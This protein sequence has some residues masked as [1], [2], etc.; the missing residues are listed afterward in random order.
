MAQILSAGSS[1][2]SQAYTTIQEAGSSLTQR[3][4]LNVVGSGLIAS[5]D[6]G[7][8]RT[9]L[10]AATALNSIASGTW[11]GA[12]SIT[13]LGTISTGTWDGTV[14]VGQ[15]GGTGVANTGK[16]ITLGGNLTTSG[17]F[18][19][20][21]TVTAGT[22]VTLPTS[23]TLVNTGVT[24]LSSLATVGTISS[25]TWNGTAVDVPHGGTGVSSTT[26]YAVLCGGTTSTGALQP[27]ASVGSSG[28]VLTSNGASALPTFQAASSGGITSVVRQV[29]TSSG[30]YVPTVGMVQAYVECIGGGSGGAGSISPALSN[31]SVGGGGGAGGYAASMLSAADIGASQTV[32]IGAGGTSSS[33]GM[34]NPGGNTTFGSLV[35]GAA[36]YYSSYGSGATSSV[37]FGRPPPYGYSGTGT[38]TLVIPGGFGEAGIAMTLV[39]GDGMGLGGNGGK[40]F[41]GYTIQSNGVLSAPGSHD[42]TDANDLTANWGSGGSGSVSVSSAG[43]QAAAATGGA[44]EAGIVIVTEYVG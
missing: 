32:T 8:S 20:T 40:S 38:G 10:T 41:Y 7:G 23:G 17:A 6:S 42:G 33:G 2:I 11:T 43:S 24:T 34:G 9:Q 3:N 15:Y 39:S 21:L 44:G 16:S 35:T 18:D 5:D 4:L 26:A 31:V 37:G 25:G 1:G 27:V 28:Y 22:S 19:T 12:N 30:T 29:F 13:T 14:I 36:G